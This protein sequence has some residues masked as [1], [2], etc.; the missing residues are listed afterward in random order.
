M[1]FA[2]SMSQN[3]DLQKTKLCVY[4][5]QGNCGLGSDCKFAH[6][7]SE[8]R[9]APNL[10]KTK[11]CAKF[12][13]GQCFRSDC[14]FAHSESELVTPPSFKKKMCIW[15]QQGKC[16]NGAKCGFAHDSAELQAGGQQAPIEA[17][18]KLSVCSGLKKMGPEDDCDAS[19][20][21]PSTWSRAESGA[22]SLSAGTVPHEHLF[23]MMAG[24]GSAPIENQVAS[25]GMAVAE[26]QSK[27]SQVENLMLRTQVGQ[28]QH[29]I[30][31]LSEQ[32]AD[33]E[34]HLRTT[35]SVVPS[36]AS[37]NGM[38][39]SAPVFEPTTTT[40]TLNPSAPVFEPAM[41]ANEPSTTAHE[42]SRTADVP[43]TSSSSPPV[44]EEF[45]K[46]SDISRSESP[47]PYAPPQRKATQK[48]TKAVP[49]KR[50]ASSTRSSQVSPSWWS[51]SEMKMALVAFLV[52]LWVMVELKQRV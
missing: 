21:V 16:R 47:P 2:K 29:T 52:S 25:M 4:F 8:V 30:S 48:A 43:N 42:L 41:A 50:A 40:A 27:L 11:M 31:Q 23:R 24:R 33:V 1:L 28:M 51:R 32:C 10:S 34:A 7:L 22:T 26:L 45:E 20:D 37:S 49:R 15:F 39:P 44:L 5:V 46:P 12:M 36:S 6:G 18:D 19:T 3:K 38:N 17:P 13:S 9:K 14:S 35:Q